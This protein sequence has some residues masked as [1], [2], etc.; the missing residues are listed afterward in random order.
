MQK[1]GLRNFSSV[2]KLLKNSWSI[3]EEVATEPVPSHTGHGTFMN[4]ET[5]KIPV[6]PKNAICFFCMPK[7][8]RNIFSPPFTAS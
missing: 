3:W 2:C 1:S 4:V 8:R 6:M 7:I 5:I